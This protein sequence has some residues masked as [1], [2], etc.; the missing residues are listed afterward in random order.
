MSTVRLFNDKTRD[1]KERIYDDY[2]K[3][4][5]SSKAYKCEMCKKCISDYREIYLS[6]KLDIELSEEEYETRRAN[7]TL[8]SEVIFPVSCEG[9]LRESMGDVSSAVTDEEFA[10][11]GIFNPDIWFEEELGIKLRWYQSD[12]ASCTARAKV[13]RWGRRCLTGD[14]LVQMGDGS[15]KPIKD[16]VIGDVVSCTDLN[17]ISY[18]NGEVSYIFDNG[19]KEVFKIKLDDGNEL[20]CTSNHPLLWVDKDGGEWSWSTIDSGLSIG[21]AVMVLSSFKDKSYTCSQILSIESIGKENTYDISIPDYENFI[22]NN[23]IVHNTGKTHH[24][25]GGLLHRAVIGRGYDGDRFI[26]EKILILAPFQAQI[27]EIF[28][29]VDEMIQSSKSL[30][31]S[32]LRRAR[33]PNQILVMSNGSKLSGFCIGSDEGSNSDKTRGQDATTIYL[34]ETCIM[35]DKDIESVMAIMASRPDTA[36]W[37]TSTPDGRRGKFWGFCNM[38]ELGFKETHITAMQSPAWNETTERILRKNYTRSA[39]ESE[40]LAIFGNVAGGVFPTDM[41]QSS[42]RNYDYGLELV[43]K[44][45]KIA[46]GID[47]NSAENGIP[48]IV[49]SYDPH[50]NAYTVVDKYISQSKNFTQLTGVQDIIRMYNKWNPHAVYLDNG[51]GNS[52]FELLTKYMMTI[53]KSEE[54][55][56]FKSITMHSK[57]FIRDPLTLKKVEKQ[58]KALMIDL[59]V[60]RVEN[61]M[62]FFPSFENQ[63]KQLVDQLR[64]FR[65]ERYTQNGIP[66]YSQGED[67]QLIAW[68]LAMYA[69]TMEFSDIAKIDDRVTINYLP[70]LLSRD[71]ITSIRSIDKDGKNL[72]TF[73]SNEY[74]KNMSWIDRKRE[75][76]NTFERSVGRLMPK[77]FKNR[78]GF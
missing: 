54:A 74:N 29:K 67:H 3:I 49:V 77:S 10:I 62:C 46:M 66:V 68:C 4:H 21:D 2:I 32:V 27:D 34:D 47:W 20:K 59:A 56:K 41:L 9:D 78:R 42:L 33:S 25:V 70:S 14:Q 13:D 30:K 51:F 58:N 5:K 28:S 57:G 6:G 52:Q 15:K 75:P 7:G 16:I 69:I 64:N 63:E 39:W 72:L 22:A 11:A 18:V 43:S 44:E 12:S 37:A 61:G 31:Y 26:P 60:Q 23:I 53:G 45:S 40:I 50:K 24:K 71:D 55:R 8:P 36:L 38:K 73:E 19:I 1:Q 48:I 76:V 65:V 35:M 17:A